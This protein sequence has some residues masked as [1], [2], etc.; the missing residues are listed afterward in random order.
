MD[1]VVICSLIFMTIFIL[2]L[3]LDLLRTSKKNEM[4][5]RIDKIAG[6]EAKIKKSE[7]SSKPKHDMLRRILA[8]AG[9]FSI[10]R[11]LGARID[12][13]L[14]EADILLSGGEFVVMVAAIVIG[15]VML[16]F[17]TTL[18]P[19]VSMAVGTVSAVIP[20]VLVDSA[21]NK[22]LADFN[23]QISD[24][25]SIMS[26]SLRSGFSFVQS[27]DMV[28]RELPNP[29]KKEFDRTVIEIN[30]GTS[31]EQ[32]LKNL[33]QRVSSDDMELVITAVLIQRQ[34]GGNLAEVLDNIAGAIRERVRIKREIKTL[35][36]Q[37]RISGLII[38]LLPIFLAVFMF[39]SNPGYIL[40]LFRNKTGLA[41]LSLAILGQLSGLMIIKKI[42]DIKF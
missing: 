28:R 12:K 7:K 10:T 27:M 38:G 5:S 16:V 41:M 19:L 9:D 34:V 39:S 35:T 32:A 3:G 22:R 15:M 20:F 37:G 6:K 8:R 31:I 36:A 4:I 2:V 26:N 25:L 17:S 30:L 24:A 1:L 29:I 13:K 33:S 18:K 40:E 14:E 23:D 11:R 42:V 21:R